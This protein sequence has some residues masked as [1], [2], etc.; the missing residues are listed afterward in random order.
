MSWCCWSVTMQ[1]K[2]NEKNSEIFRKTPFNLEWKSSGVRVYIVSF[3]KKVF[4]HARKKQWKIHFELRIEPT[5]LLFGQFCGNAPNTFHI[6]KFFYRVDNKTPT[7][8]DP[9]WLLVE[10]SPCFHPRKYSLQSGQCRFGA[11]LMPVL[12]R[13]LASNYFKLKLLKVV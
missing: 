3:L 12:I 7:S 1:S 6:W 4:Q 13:L 9:T 10:A 5:S 2:N 8:T 11:A